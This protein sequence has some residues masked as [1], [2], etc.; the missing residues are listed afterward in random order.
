FH[1]RRELRFAW[2]GGAEV[3]GL[4]G[5]TAGQPHAAIVHRLQPAFEIVAD[6]LVRPGLERAAAAIGVERG[7]ERSERVAPLDRA[8]RQLAC[9]DGD[10][11]RDE[12]RLDQ[13][14]S[15]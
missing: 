11:L 13:H 15:A 2:W 4:P 7:L 8:Q 14:E 12:Y 6:G 3:L 9:A 1:R 10:V 5:G